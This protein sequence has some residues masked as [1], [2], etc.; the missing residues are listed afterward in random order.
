MV[1]TSCAITNVNI[2][3]LSF[4]PIH[5]VGVDC[6]LIYYEQHTVFCGVVKTSFDTRLCKM[7]AIAVRDRIK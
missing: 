1:S 2:V 7:T 6:K 3:V 4:T 5:F